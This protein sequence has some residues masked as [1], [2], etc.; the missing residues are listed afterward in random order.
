MDVIRELSLY[1]TVMNATRHHFLDG[2]FDAVERNRLTGWLLSRRNPGG[3][4]LF[5]LTPE[6]R[7]AK[8]PLLTGEKPKTYLLAENALECETLRLL[9]LLSPANPESEQ[10]IAMADRRLRR[11][12]FA[13]VCLTGECPHVSIAYLRFLTSHPGSETGSRL[14]HGV[15]VLSQHRAGDGRWQKFPFWYTLL[16]LVDLPA[17]LAKD[18]L[19]YAVPAL[20]RAKKL[21]ISGPGSEVRARIVE[22]VA[23]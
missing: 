17:N 12:C 16:W 6:E 23:L 1:E 4:F 2:M 9:A 10:A 3:G 19:V 13:N 20:E 15:E 14:R 11:Q 22:R 18:E 7:T 5:P 8:P 21:G